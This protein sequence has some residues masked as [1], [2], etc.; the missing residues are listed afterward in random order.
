MI[1]HEAQTL[2]GLC[3]SDRKVNNKNKLINVVVQLNRDK[4][5]KRELMVLTFV[6]RR[7]RY[8][9]E[10]KREWFWRKVRGIEGKKNVVGS[11]GG[12]SSHS[13]CSTC[14]P[15]KSD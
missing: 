10:W 6:R 15:N 3:S 12:L 5:I 13:T 1:N 2:Q 7:G 4:V 9:R 14:H 8:R 11:G